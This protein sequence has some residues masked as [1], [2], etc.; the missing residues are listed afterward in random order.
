MSKRDSLT[1]RRSLIGCLHSLVR[2]DLRK[3]QLKLYRSEMAKTL[4]TSAWQKISSSA[5]TAVGELHSSVRYRWY[6]LAYERR[7]LKVG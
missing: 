2:I 1:N 3:K 6:Q 4:E 5:L 7:H